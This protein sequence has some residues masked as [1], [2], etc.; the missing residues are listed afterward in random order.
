MII[1]K[2]VC[3]IN[4]L[5]RIQNKRMR[6][7]SSIKKALAVLLALL[8]SLG[9]CSSC[10]NK[11]PIE[12]GTGTLPDTG[13]SSATELVLVGGTAGTYVIVTPTYPTTAETQ[14]AKD[15]KAKI[16]E[17]TGVALSIKKDLVREGTDFVASD[18]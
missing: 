4:W 11:E 9:G 8:L 2:G 7:K 14:A 5:C 3:C 17:L 15:L 18:Y 6:H 13:G 12:D 16:Q 10:S 1:K